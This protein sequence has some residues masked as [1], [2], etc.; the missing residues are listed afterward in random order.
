M[1]LAVCKGLHAQQWD[2]VILDWSDNGEKEAKL[3]NGLFIK[4]DVSDYDSIS[5]AFAQVWAK[6]G[7]VNFVFANAGIGEKVNWYAPIQEDENGLPPRPNLTTVNVDLIGV[8]YTAYLAMH[9]FRKVVTDTPKSIIMTASS[10]SLYPLD[11][12]P[13]YTTAKHGVLGLMRA[14]APRLKKEKINVNCILPGTVAT[15][16]VDPSFWDN[17]PKEYMTPIEKVVE[18]VLSLVN[19]PNASGQAVEVIIDKTYIRDAHPILDPRLQDIMQMSNDA[20]E[21]IIE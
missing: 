11:I 2:I 3:L 17:F 18:V 12:F 8:I 21:G 6:Y 15:N 4:T 16:I 9:F 10:S 1:G 19:N 5:K 13:L 14:L 20:D 7:R